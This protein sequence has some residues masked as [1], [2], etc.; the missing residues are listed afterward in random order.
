MELNI[1]IRAVKQKPMANMDFMRT[2][3]E[4]NRPSFHMNKR[5]PLTHTQKFWF[6]VNFKRC[7]LANCCLLAEPPST[8][9]PSFSLPPSDKQHRRS[10]VTQFWPVSYKSRY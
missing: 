4:T 7:S 8:S 9:K 10:H 6:P 1:P 5:P 3:E 2:C